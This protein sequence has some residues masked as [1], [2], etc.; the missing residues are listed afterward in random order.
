MYI[1]FEKQE[2]GP[3]FFKNTGCELLYSFWVYHIGYIPDENFK[4][5]PKELNAI[6]LT[7][8]IAKASKFASVNLTYKKS[9]KFRVGSHVF[10]DIRHTVPPELIPPAP[11][12]WEYHIT[13]E[14]EENSVKFIKIIL[15]DYM[16]VHFNFLE[17]HEFLKHIYKKRLIRSKLDKCTTNEQ[18]QLVM[19]EHFGFKAHQFYVRDHNLGEEKWNITSEGIDN[20][21]F[22]PRYID[23]GPTKDNIDASVF[24]LDWKL[25]E[26][27]TGTLPQE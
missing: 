22:R 15:D 8:E 10:E 19:H 1:T 26:E 23:P 5:L 6:Q 7:S 4:L 9:I 16:R 25:T 21:H 14:D 17:Q 11:E 13:N 3:D 20:N 2:L 24:S 18:C 12:K 27:V